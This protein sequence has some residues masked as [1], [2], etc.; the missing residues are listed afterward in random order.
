MEKKNYLEI[1]DSAIAAN[2]GYWLP[3]ATLAIAFS[4]I[5]FL[6]LYIYKRE[7]KQNDKRH[8]ENEVL[9]KMLTESQSKIST[10]LTKLEI[11]VEY[12]KK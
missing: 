8:E 6:L 4:L 11:E 1:A 7:Q 3:L 2:N 12:L 5:I 10:V 9:I